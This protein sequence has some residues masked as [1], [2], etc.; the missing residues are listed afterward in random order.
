MS[1]QTCLSRKEWRRITGASA[2]VPLHER[3]AVLLK[4]IATYPPGRWTSWD[5]E[6]RQKAL[7]LRREYRKE[8]K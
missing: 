5:K 8:K 7:S 1:N 2:P 3:A 6:Q 4:T